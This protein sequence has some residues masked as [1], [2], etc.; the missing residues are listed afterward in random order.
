MAIALYNLLV[1]YQPVCTHCHAVLQSSVGFHCFVG[2][3]QS[4]FT[5]WLTRDWMKLSGRRTSFLG[6]GNSC[7]M[8]FFFCC[9]HFI[10]QKINIYICGMQGLDLRL[11]SS[12][13]AMCLG[14][15]T[16]TLRTR[17]ILG[18]NLPLKNEC[19]LTWILC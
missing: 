2:E 1:M 9:C 15:L 8:I 14:C 18:E 6:D 4:I 19:I 11:R 10:L 17:K 16:K 7:G 12:V 13:E 3:V 5:I